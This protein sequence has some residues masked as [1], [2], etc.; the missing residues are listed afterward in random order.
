V[1]EVE[2]TVRV[3]PGVP[4]VVFADDPSAEAPPGPFPE[5]VRAAAGRADAALAGLHDV[6]SRVADRRARLDETL[7]GAIEACR[8]LAASM[9]AS[10][11][12]VPAE[13]L[14]PRLPI[15]EYFGVREAAISPGQAAT[16]AAAVVYRGLADLQYPLIDVNDMAVEVATMR[17]VLADLV[18]SPGPS[19]TPASP[20][21]RPEVD[22]Q[23]S[24]AGLERWIVAH[25][26]YFLFNLRAAAEVQAGIRALERGAT[27][28]AAQHLAR[29][30]R[31]VRGFTAAMAHS[32][33]MPAG[34]YADHVR[35]TM[36]PPHAPVNLTG[37][38]QPQHKAFRAAV[39]R[40]ID[41]LPDEYDDLAEREP[42]L[43]SARSALLNADLIDI[44]R[45]AH[46]ADRLIGD[47]H[48][49]VQHDGG[50]ENAVSMLR[51]MRHLRAARYAPLTP[52]GDRLVMAAVARTR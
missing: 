34:Y 7:A 31:Y 41:R 44:E 5:P 14:L 27:G 18:G 45:H 33:A 17:L 37:S 49:L 3:L 35:H 40:L 20:A 38:M 13:E 23:P 30:A 2:H 36:G 26:V 43:A 29:A 10:T 21:P 4:L 1:R 39:R 12:P 15:H 47:D 25:H 51:T 46:V 16:H 22:Y 32:A 48:S 11:Q 42:G 28:K 8:M 19:R 24:G 52:F 50:Q 6:A 9:A